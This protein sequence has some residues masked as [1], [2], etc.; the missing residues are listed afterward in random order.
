MDLIYSVVNSGVA[1]F[2]NSYSTSAT[3]LLSATPGL[4]ASSKVAHVLDLWAHFDITI[5]WA[6]LDSVAF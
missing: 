5:P 3:E 4:A 6:G 1:C 2:A